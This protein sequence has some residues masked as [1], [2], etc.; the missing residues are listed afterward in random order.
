MTHCNSSSCDN[1]CSYSKCIF[2]CASTSYRLKNDKSFIVC[3]ECQQNNEMFT[4]TYCINNLLLNKSDL[5][6]IKCF[7]K[8]NQKLY[9]KDDIQI[10]IMLKY[11]NDYV[12]YKEKK[13][14]HKYKRISNINL[15]RDE[16]KE[17][18]MEKLAEYKLEYKNYGDCY[19]YV[20]FG[21]PDVD[22]VIINELEKY[23]NIFS[24]QQSE[25][26]IYF[27]DENTLSF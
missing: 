11:G 23:R 7:Y 19:S 5:N 1:I 9:L 10:L 15:Q 21:F 22:I 6:S 27:L 2:C 3:N 13:L 17:K 20:Q 4:R 26:E 24:K 8:S 16:R 12:N 14:L 25:P 18:L